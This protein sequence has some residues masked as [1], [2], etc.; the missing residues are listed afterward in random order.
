MPPEPLPWDRKDFVSKERKHDRGAGSDA[1]GGGGASST[2]WWREPYHGPRPFF[3]A[4]PRRPPS[5]H[6]RQ[7]GGYHQFY[8][9]DPASHGCTPS[10]SDRFWIEDE[11][12]R[13]SGRYGGGGGSN[14]SG[15]GGGG[16]GG[17]NSREGRGSFRRSPF[18]D[19]SSS[20]YFSSSS[21]QNNHHDHHHP[22][23]VTAPRS[24]AVPISSPTSHQPPLKDHQND[25]NNA[26]GVDDGSGT[27]QRSDRDHPLGSI[28]W[29]PLKWPRSSSLS[30]AKSGRSEPEEG[31]LEVSV[32]SGQETPIRSPVTSPQ[33][34]D[35]GAARKKPRLGWGQGLAKYERQKV[36]G[37]ID[38][39]SPS[40]AGGA[41]CSSPAT[42]SSATCSSSPALTDDKICTKA[43]N[44]ENETN[45]Q[46]ASGLGFQHCSGESLIK[47]DY[48]DNPIGSLTSI[49]ADLLGPEDACSGDSTST[50]LVAVNKLFQLKG[51]VSKELEKTESEIDL[52]ESVLK[53]VDSTAEND[54]HLPSNLPA[55]NALESCLGASDGVS[56]NSKDVEMGKLEAVPSALM[57]FK[58]SD[59]KD[60]QTEPAE[61]PLRLKD[62]TLEAT[63]ICDDGKKHSTEDVSSRDYA[64]IACSHGRTSCNLISL[65]TAS[66]QD[67]ERR[68]LDV[69]NK[70]LPTN[71]SKTDIWESSDLSR[72]RKN[73]LKVKEKIAVRKRIL[74]FKEQ[75]LSL[76]FRAFHHLWKEDLRLLSVR[77]SR[78]KSNKRVDISNYSSHS[79]SQKQRSSIRSRFALPAGNV[80]LVPTT[81]IVEFTSKLLSDSQT[82]LCRSYLKMPALILDNEEKK[83]A[84][85]ITYNGIIE[86]PISLEKEKAKVNPWS[87]EEKDIFMEKLAAFGKDFG[88]ISSFLTHKTTAD[89]VEFYYKN[90]KSESFSEVKKL[91]DLRKQQQCLPTSTYLL[92]SDKRWNP[93]ANAASL[94]MLE[95]ASFV[96]EH[97]QSVKEMSGNERESI[98]AGVLAG[99]CG[100]ISSEAMSSCIT[101]TI[102]PSEKIKYV[103]NDRQLATEVTQNLDE[104][105]TCSDENCG[106]V[107]SVDWTDDEKSVFIRA[108]S[109]YGKDFARISQCVGTR[110][111]EQCKIFFSKARKC[112]G[113]DAVLQGNDNVGILPTSDTNGGRSDTDDICAAEIDSAICSTQ[114][115]SK[116]DGDVSQSVANGNSE[117]LAHAGADRSSENEV[118]GGINLENESKI[119]RNLEEN[120]SK[121]E[122]N[123]EENESEVGINLEENESKVGINLEENESKVGIN[124]EENESKVGINLEENERKVEINLEENGSKVD[125]QQ[126]VVHDVKV[127]N[128]E[129]KEESYT[130]PKNSVAALSCKEPVEPEVAENIDTEKKKVEGGVIPPSEAFVTAG[131]EGKLNSQT[132]C[133]IQQKDATGVLSSNGLRKEVNLHQPL[134]PEVG[135]NRRRRAS[136]DLG[137]SSSYTL[138]FGSDPSANENNLYLE[139]SFGVCSRLTT[140]S[141][142][143]LHQLPLELRTCLPKKTQGITLKQ[144]NCQS[145]QSSAV[146]SNPS[147]ICF[148]GT[149]PSQIILNSDEHTN[150]RHQ[151]SAARDLYQQ[152]VLKNPSLNQVDQPLQ[153]LKGYPLQIFNQNE[154]KRE[155]VPS[156]SGNPFLLESHS[157]RNG[158]SQSNPFFVWNAQKDKCNGSSVSHSSSATLTPSKIDDKSEVQQSQ[159]TGDIKL[160]GK[161]LSQPSSQKSTSSPPENKSRPLSPATNG[162]SALAKPSNIV[163]DGAPHSSVPGSSSKT[164]L[165]ELPV[166]SYGFWDGNRIQTGFSSLSESALMLAKYQGSLAGVSL[167]KDGA[168]G[169]NAI[170]KDYHPSFLQHLSSDG[171]RVENFTE[172]QK[173]GAGIEPMSGFKQ[174]GRAVVRL[175]A[176]NIVG[177]AGILADGAVSDPVAALKMLYPSSGQVIGAEMK[178]WTGDIGGR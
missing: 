73:D 152:Y 107:A 87:Q 145:V 110:S 30:S 149:H 11:G 116:V 96:A 142:N 89:C 22:P 93:G 118:A 74:K 127:E 78:T 123:F 97:T 160:F 65:I 141:T 43:V 79:G 23:P 66:N 31:K 143:N 153:V 71:Q 92:T 76:K 103:A 26:G 46:S 151:C 101:T 131:L 58:E 111:R 33:P 35:E 168:P 68:A 36:Q 59:I 99:I 25:K 75:A 7:G 41:G 115:C 161:I 28:S 140:I 8:P 24:V 157:R 125:K 166:R 67:S 91:L 112:L 109:T 62:D 77:K 85:F 136:I 175:G 156:V 94:D 49:L 121:V 10:R 51:D 106:E 9:E 29:K 124:L 98:A 54:C 174:S 37:S 122:R 167:Y 6:Y 18:W 162:S 90:H 155:S 1:L 42:P 57:H 100:A 95:A 102:S 177:P 146:F 120:E 13:P 170:I 44:S 52:L 83:H 55:S 173:R 117:G 172:L 4:S 171:K 130:T 40:A 56:E 133:V 20:G 50:R 61:C 14:R 2:P 17:S 32:P 48:L 27:G 60:V 159:L 176:A 88:R 104:E 105:D 163:N 114:S 164:G 38:L 134:A 84:K 158:A 129:V 169:G 128:E 39:T 47:L 119:G 5:G 19:S 81:E 86:D 147:S 132:A 154:V 150:K 139:N 21:R 165:E 113:L 45:N 148:D 126:C 82:K 3:R 80:T 53:T 69:F 64:I 16:G 70:T 15:G 72:H 137:T 138:C 34:S 144:E 12:F 135:S 178:S 63:S 108:L